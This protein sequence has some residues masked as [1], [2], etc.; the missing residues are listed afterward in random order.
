MVWSLHEPSASLTAPCFPL[1]EPVLSP[2]PIGLEMGEAWA[3]LTICKGSSKAIASMGAPAREQS[4]HWGKLS[5]CA[6][7]LLLTSTS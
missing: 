7:S 1:P 6:P 4:W 2:H 5:P 3:S